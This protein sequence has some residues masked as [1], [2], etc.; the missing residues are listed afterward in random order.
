MRYINDHDND[1]GLIAE[2]VLVQIYRYTVWL[3]CLQSSLLKQQFISHLL[4][5]NSE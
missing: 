3:H 4:I 5:I 1:D 2:N